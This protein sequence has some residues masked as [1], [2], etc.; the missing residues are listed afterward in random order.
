MQEE[1]GREGEVM[2][3][4]RP[5]DYKPEYCE[6]VVELGRKGFSRVQIAAELDVAKSTIQEWE[7]VHPEFSASMTRAMTLSQAWWE[8]KGQDC[9]IM[10]AGATFQ[11][12][13]W[14]R[15][16]AAR[17]PEDWRE[18]SK[19]ENTHSAPDGSPLALMAQITGVAIAPQ[20]SKE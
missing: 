4:G 2:P 7:K 1:Q 6:R 9:L 3:A 10:P 17:F 11:G 15:S 8:Q 5:T 19:V 18:N 20:P 16:M 13:V 12:S 14:S